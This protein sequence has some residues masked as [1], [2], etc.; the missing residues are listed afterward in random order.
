MWSGSMEITR[1]T[2]P[3]GGAVLE[4][5]QTSRTVFDTATSLVLEYTDW[6]TTPVMATHHLEVSLICLPMRNQGIQV[7][8]HLTDQSLKHLRLTLQ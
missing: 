7:K 3:T 2:K 5:E 4:Q 1:N 6:N 8:L